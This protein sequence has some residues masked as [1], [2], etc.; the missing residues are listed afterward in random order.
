MTTHPNDDKDD[1][2]A[3]SISNYPLPADAGRAAPSSQRTAEDHQRRRWFL[4]LVTAVI[5]GLLTGALLAPVNHAIHDITNPIGSYLVGTDHSVEL[6]PICKDL[7]GLVAP[8]AEKNA[9]YQY[10]CR[11]SKQTITRQQIAQRCRIQ[12]GPNAKLVLRDPDSASG[13]TCHTPGLVHQIPPA[14]GP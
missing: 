1:H 5:A 12:W 2:E 8:P 14:T 4:G 7:G 13:W 6:S 11:D 3:E 9:A 10:Q